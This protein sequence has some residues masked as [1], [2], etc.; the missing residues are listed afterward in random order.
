MPSEPKPGLG[1]SSIAPPI[2]RHSVLDDI[3][4]LGSGVIVVSLGL[5]LLRAGGVVTGGTAGVALLLSYAFPV[6][7]GWL[8]VLVNLPF[9]LLAIRRK[10]WN[11]TIRSGLSIV[12][13]S[14]LS[15]FHPG[16][17][18][19]GAIGEVY[20]SVVGNVLA[21]VGLVILFR[22]HSSLGGFNI[23]ALILQD[24]TRLRAGYVLMV[25]DTLVVVS[26]LAVVPP[27][28]VAISALGVV[29]LNLVLALNHRPGRY[30]GG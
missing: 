9:F 3:V 27:R 13:V 1:E 28:S 25:L 8:F 19:L 11:F 10:G 14:A 7:F 30:F 2:L 22:H 16:Q 29:L 26:S 20:A 12:A 18:H 23:V 15:A 4:G 24:R 17:L 6:S 5:A 21:A